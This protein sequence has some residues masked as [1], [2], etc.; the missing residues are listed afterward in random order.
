M[1]QHVFFHD[2]KTWSWDNSIQVEFNSSHITG[3]KSVN[4]GEFYRKLT[5]RFSFQ[6]FSIHSMSKW[7]L[8]Q[9]M[10]S[11][12]FKIC[13]LYA[14]SILHSGSLKYC[15]YFENSWSLAANSDTSVGMMIE[16]AE[17]ILTGLHDYIKAQNN[18]QQVA[19]HDDRP[20][21]F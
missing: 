18:G 10:F 19:G 21:I 16:G 9:G 2:N 12:L 7:I 6:H 11:W 3:I 14:L 5:F 4:V 1:L 13:A 15:F 20:N 8:F 17:T